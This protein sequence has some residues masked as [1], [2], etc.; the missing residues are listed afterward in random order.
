M[1]KLVSVS[2][3]RASLPDLVNKVSLGVDRITITVKGQP[4]ATL[5][6]AEELLSLE[7]TAEVLSIPGAKVS[8]LE[9]L[10]E[11]K[12]GKGISISEL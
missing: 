10:K 5:V 3:A 4:K 1:D 7:E 8:I 12:K 6:S 9:G 11:A 2:N